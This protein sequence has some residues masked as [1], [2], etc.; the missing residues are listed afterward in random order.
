[1]DHHVDIRKRENHPIEIAYIAQ[2]KAELAL[3]F[4]RKL[5]AHLRL[6]EFV[7][8]I[9]DQSFD[10]WEITQDALHEGFPE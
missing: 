4:G 1:M 6:L 10:I 9:N 5:S 8:R 3:L 2:E 7:A